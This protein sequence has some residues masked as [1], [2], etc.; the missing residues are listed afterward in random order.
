M[1]KL[2]F[3]AGAVLWVYQS[4][5][6]LLAKIAL[7]AAVVIFVWPA[8]AAV[9]RSVVWLMGAVVVFVLLLLFLP[10]HLYRSAKERKEKTPQQHFIN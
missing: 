4:P 6:S 2:L 7:G 1:M 5:D 3:L 8:I 10:Y 9:A